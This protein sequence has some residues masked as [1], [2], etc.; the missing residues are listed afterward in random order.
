[1]LHKC[2]PLSTTC[3]VARLLHLAS[4]SS[5]LLVRVELARLQAKPGNWCVLRLFSA[6]HSWPAGHRVLFPA[7]AAA[8]F[9]ALSLISPLPCR[10]ERR[11]PCFPSSRDIQTRSCCLSRSPSSSSSGV[12]QHCQITNRMR[13]ASGKLSRRAVVKINLGWAP[14][15][16]HRVPAPRQRA[17]N[18]RCGMRIA[19]GWR[20]LP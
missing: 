4:R 3:S 10:S 7:P 1:V 5:R 6:A 15:H 2:S 12:G 20:Y 19:Q 17:H 14:F 18:L 11:R 16:T 8:L 13:C 9:P